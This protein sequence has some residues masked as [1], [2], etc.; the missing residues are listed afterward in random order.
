MLDILLDGTLNYEHAS[1]AES[2]TDNSLEGIPTFE[3]KITG[4]L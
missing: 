1:A 2:V 4:S 3:A